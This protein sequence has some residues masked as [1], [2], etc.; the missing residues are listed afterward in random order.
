M[1]N[2]SVEVANH[3]NINDVVVLAGRLRN[4]HPHGRPLPASP[5]G[6]MQ[7]QQRTETV[8]GSGSKGGFRTNTSALTNEVRSMRTTALQ[9]QTVNVN[10]NVGARPDEPCTPRGL[11]NVVN[12]RSQACGTSSSP[13]ALLVQRRPPSPN[14]VVLSDRVDTLILALDVMT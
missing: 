1:T 5:Q 7:R 9:Q 8:R 13:H 10:S 6:A 12:N 2:D 11:P 3:W 14:I 4:E